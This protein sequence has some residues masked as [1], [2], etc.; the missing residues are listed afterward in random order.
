MFAL[1]SIYNFEIN[2]IFSLKF[3]KLCI[4]LII[5]LN[6]LKNDITLDISMFKARLTITIIFI[7]MFVFTK[8]AI[9]QDKC[10][11]TD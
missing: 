7:L 10:K 4:K 8:C 6:W 5:T 3:I 2:N 11:W 1:S 9:I